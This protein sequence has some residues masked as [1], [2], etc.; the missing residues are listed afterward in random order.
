MCDRVIFALVLIEIYSIYT[1]AYK[2]ARK[3]YN[4]HYCCVAKLRILAITWRN[5]IRGR[6]RRLAGANE[7]NT[8][9][10]KIT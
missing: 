10:L 7:L 5:V 8:Q 9:S 6:E 2:N 3:A 1:I 4:A